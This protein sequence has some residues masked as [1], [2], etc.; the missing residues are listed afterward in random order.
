LNLY[1][2]LV[3]L[4]SSLAV[5]H[6]ILLFPSLVSSNFEELSLIPSAEFPQRKSTLP[7][8]QL[9]EYFKTILT[10]LS[11]HTSLQMFLLSV[12]FQFPSFAV[13]VEFATEKFLGN[14]QN[15][16][17]SPFQLP[18]PNNL[19]LIKFLRN[20]ELTY[21]SESRAASPTLPLEAKKRY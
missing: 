12:K 3:V 8:Q 21:T 13:T 2:F 14:L 16:T 17:S 10:A 5:F 19:I 7:K 4:L 9:D 11:P 1:D 20:D 6:R 18:I 15:P